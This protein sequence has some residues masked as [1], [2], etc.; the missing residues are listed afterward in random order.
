MATAPFRLRQ[1][2]T[3]LR[4]ALTFGKAAQAGAASGRAVLLT[5][6]GA[7]GG[8]A[9]TILGILVGLPES[10]EARRSAAIR[11]I[12]ASLRL[13]SPEELPQGEESADE[14]AA[15]E[16]R[17]QT[18]LELRTLLRRQCADGVYSPEERAEL[19]EWSYA[20][21]YSGAHQEL[22]RDLLEE[23]RR[24][25]QL[26]PATLATFVESERQDHC[27]ATQAVR[28]GVR[29]EKDGQTD[30][31]REK[32]LE[33][34]RLDPGNVDAWLNL[35]NVFQA[36]GRLDKAEGALRSASALGSSGYK[37]FAV[38][39]S[40][41]NCLARLPGK[42]EAALS[43]LLRA[44]EVYV[45]EKL[46]DPNADYLRRDLGTGAEFQALRQDPGFKDLLS[47]EALAAR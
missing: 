2:G 42:R 41:A 16:Q 8:V 26:F 27:G 17:E 37:R 43:Q 30:A 15:R 20:S 32:F 36:Q 3:L 19:L 38:E 31:A 14:K 35:G 7:A 24:A 33:A 46:T 11:E 12:E 47:H 18:A 25:R 9:L 21:H 6:L 10:E 5:R 44:L 1:L 29:L 45:E 22:Y 28:E 40:L 13:G 4:Q 23:A 34:T 39:Y